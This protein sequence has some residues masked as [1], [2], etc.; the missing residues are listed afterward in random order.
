[1][2]DGLNLYNIIS[3]NSN[4]FSDFTFGQLLYRDS[5]FSMI[6]TLFVAGVNFTFSAGQMPSTQI[7]DRSSESRTIRSL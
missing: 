1:M 2:R 3:F 4:L 7:T 6:R 5:S